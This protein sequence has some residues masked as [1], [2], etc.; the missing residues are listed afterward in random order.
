[1][2]QS[3]DVSKLE[4]VHR[5]TDW[6]DSKQFLK[7]YND[8]NGSPLVGHS[9]VWLSHCFM[10]NY[11]FCLKGDVKIWILLPRMLGTY[12]VIESKHVGKK[13]GQSR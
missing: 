11:P 5:Q 2:S 1:M 13:I 12:L 3:P 10:G 7:S 6:E 4:N 8:R 9:V